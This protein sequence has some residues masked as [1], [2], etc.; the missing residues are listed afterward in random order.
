MDVFAVQIFCRFREYA[1]GVG[2]NVAVA[3]LL[4]LPEKRGPL[5]RAICGGQDS[6]ERMIPGMGPRRRGGFFDYSVDV[7]ATLHWR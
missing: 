2:P 7:S 4:I 5:V 1:L 3:R 6:E